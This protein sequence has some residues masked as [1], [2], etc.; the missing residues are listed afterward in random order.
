MKKPAPALPTTAQH[1]ISVR[2]AEAARI[3]DISQAT[4]WRWQQQRPDMPRPR[5]LSYKT[6]LFDYAELIAWRDSHGADGKIK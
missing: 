3:F 4:F 1:P 6:T 2:A 5:R